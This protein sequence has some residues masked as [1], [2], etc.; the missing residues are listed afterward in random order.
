MFFS[1][2]VS[3]VVFAVA[4]Y[5]AS[6][7]APFYSSSIF[8]ADFV[9]GLS[10]CLAGFA[11]SPERRHVVMAFLASILTDGETQ[12]A[13]A[14]AAL[15]GGCKAGESFELAT[16]RFRSIS[17][18]DLEEADF[19]DNREA[20]GKSNTL[21]KKTVLAKLGACDAFI[22]HSWY[23]PIHLWNRPIPPLCVTNYTKAIT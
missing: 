15:L 9:N 5:I 3:T 13:A 17:F 12:N 21:F 4:L 18:A 1:T 20:E 16:E 10:W 7:S 6:D 14:V 22:S 2:G 8:V 19:I 23:G 11:C